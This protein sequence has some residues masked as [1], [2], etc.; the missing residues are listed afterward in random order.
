M[1]AVANLRESELS[2]DVEEMQTIATVALLKIAST[3][4]AATE[5]RRTAQLRAELVSLVRRKLF[6]RE[7]MQLDEEIVGAFPGDEIVVVE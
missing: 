1:D 2:A 5:Y 4:L 6:Q 7:H 3:M